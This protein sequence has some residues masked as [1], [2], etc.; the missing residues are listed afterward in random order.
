MVLPAVIAPVRV[1]RLVT[2]LADVR[3]LGLTGGV[4]AVAGDAGVSAGELN[5]ML[6]LFG[7]F[8]CI[9]AVALLAVVAPMRIGRPVTVLAHVSRRRLTGSVTALTSDSG[10]SAAELERERAPLIPAGS[11]GSRC[12]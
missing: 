7:P 3:G 1:A 11:S 9:G 8:E 2:V 4:A 10:V 6:D 12:Q 5:R